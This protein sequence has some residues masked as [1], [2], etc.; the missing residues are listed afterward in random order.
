MRLGTRDREQGRDEMSILIRESMEY[1]AHTNPLEYGNVQ[2]ALAD[3]Y[4]HGRLASPCEEE[5]QAV[6]QYLK[7][8]TGNFGLRETSPYRLRAMAKGIL[9]T[10]RKAITPTVEKQQENKQ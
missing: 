7:D 4:A 6:V 5:V 10:A 8:S 1:A 3:A 9:R 2:D